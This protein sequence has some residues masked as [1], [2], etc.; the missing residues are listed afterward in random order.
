MK[1][2]AISDVHLE[3]NPLSKLISRGEDVL[4]ILGNL[5]T[6][7]TR[8]KALNLISDYLRSNENAFVMYVLG[9]FEYHHSSIRQTEAF[10]NNQA[11]KRKGRLMVFASKPRSVIFRR[12]RFIGCTLWTDLNDGKDMWSAWK[13]SDD[14]S[15]IRD[16]ADYPKTHLLLYKNSLDSIEEF[17]DNRRMDTIILSHHGPSRKSLPRDIDQ[18]RLFY[19]N[20]ETFIIRHPEIVY[21]FHGNS[22]TIEYT[23]GE[24]KIF[25]NSYFDTEEA[26]SDDCVSRSTWLYPLIKRSL[27]NLQST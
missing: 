2:N 12:I 20:M 9:N 1:L 26:E 11:K 27:A 14:F 4:L 25:C 13:L 7:K 3:N 24:C 17:L 19:T 16:F 10:W 8:L 23:I 18:P 5:C 22:S 15:K 21:W 6:F